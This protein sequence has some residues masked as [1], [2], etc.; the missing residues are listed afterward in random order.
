MTANEIVSVLRGLRACE[1]SVTWARGLPSGTTLQ[2]AWDLCPR[3]DWLLWVLG[4]AKADRRLFVLAACACARTS[5]RFVTSDEKRPRIA[6]ETAESWARGEA[7]DDEVLEAVYAAIGADN[8]ADA[9]ARA[10]A[11]AAAYAFRATAYAVDAATYAANAAAVY[12]VHE[13]A[14]TI[15]CEALAR[16]ADI[17]RGFFPHPPTVDFA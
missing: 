17:V 5:L 11:R 3:A 1:E 15:R 12:A 9:Y 4:E 2:Q 16:M 14:D 6:I 7:L 8:N 13:V 10:A